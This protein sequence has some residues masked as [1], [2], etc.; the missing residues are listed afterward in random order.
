MNNNTISVECDSNFHGACMFED[1]CCG[2]HAEEKD[3][4]G[5]RFIGT[6]EVKM[7]T[8]DIQERTRQWIESR[9]GEKAMNLH[10][11]GLRQYEE[12]NE[13]AQALGVSLLEALRIVI[14]VYSKKIGDIEQELGGAALTLLGCAE[15]F[16]MHLG[17]CAEKELGRI[18]S[19]PPEKF[20][21]RQDQNVRDG[22]GEPR[23]EN[24]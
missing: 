21:K 7:D 6:E 3:Y 15:G 4:E 14:H 12:S 9:L 22:I 2:C 5:E 11:R 17:W 20:R 16:G 23:E 8:L 24:L 19:L 10:E 1:C 13:L 18:E